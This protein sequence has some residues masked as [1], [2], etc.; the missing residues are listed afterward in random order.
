MDKY[1]EFFKKMKAAG[2]LAARSLEEITSP[3]VTK[4]ALVIFAG[5]IDIF[6]I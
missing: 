6:I 3:K 1:S 2:D 5:L 4:F